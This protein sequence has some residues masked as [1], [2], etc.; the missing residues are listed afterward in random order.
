MKN[1]SLLGAATVASFSILSCG[2]KGNSISNQSLL[3]SSTLSSFSTQV[4]GT[5]GANDT[6]CTPSKL[7]GRVYAAGAMLGPSGPGSEG[8]SMTFMAATDEV[9]D[10]PSK[11]K[12]GS[13]VFDVLNDDPYSGKASIPTADAMPSNPIVS[14]IEF[15]FDYLD[16]TFALTGTTGVDATYTIRTVYVSEA[17]ASDVTGTMLR[18]DK[19]IK[20]STETAFKW[21]SASGCSE[22]RPASP[23]QHAAIASWE[24]APGQQGGTDYTPV[25][26]DI[27]AASQKTFTHAT[28]SDITKVWT[29]DL[30]VANAVTFSAQPNTFDSVQEIVDKYSFAYAP[31]SSQDGDP[32]TA[33]TATFDITDAPAA[34]R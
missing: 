4:V 13:I 27:A 2:S 33:L 7:T 26:F 19:L 34:T 12:G 15:K 29:V 18:G 8:Y 32:V 14:S 10:D 17:T 3:V 28:L 16:T 31:A 21:C 5:C 9:I 20:S 22:T 25:S 24:L 23:Y 1:L 30:A 11:G 6:A